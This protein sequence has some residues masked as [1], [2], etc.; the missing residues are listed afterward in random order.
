MTV[1]DP[2]SCTPADLA[3]PAI[4]QMDL[5]RIAQFRPDLHP[6]VRK[7]PACYPELAV[8]IEQRAALLESEAAEQSTAERAV[9][10]D[11]AAADSTWASA[12]SATA[13]EPSSRSASG[14]ASASAD[15]T[16]TP[17]GNIVSPAVV[18]VHS[19][20]S[21][22]SAPEII[23][24]ASAPEIITAVPGMEVPAASEP[25]APAAAMPGAPGSGEAPSGP[26]ADPVRSSAP[27]TSPEPLIPAFAV[28]SGGDQPASER[29][30]PRD[31]NGAASLW[32]RLL[33]YAVPVL[34]ILC[35]VSTFLPIV[36]ITF[37]T[38]TWSFNYWNGDGLQEA[39]MLLAVFI[40]ATGIALAAI[41]TPQRSRLILTGIASTVSALLAVS[42]GFRN[43]IRFSGDAPDL[44]GAT[45]ASVGSGAILLAVSGAILLLI[46]VLHL[47]FAVRDEPDAWAG[48]G[49]QPSPYQQQGLS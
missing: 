46:S 7:H 3:N 12:A 36:T 2:M 39:L 21:A 24:P 37:D 11:G 38:G 30:F 14:A 45:G 17:V 32:R 8:W 9:S 6:L 41:I 29:S 4:T 26:S 1:L 33:L 43:I 18:S 34:S 23:P 47:T 40:I 42:D 5:A 27:R 44:E 10:D 31:E 35:L 28:P 48:G 25:T 13:S 22:H 16:A 20:R 19:A 15:D 49:D